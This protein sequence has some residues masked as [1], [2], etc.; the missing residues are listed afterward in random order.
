MPR[1][2]K[3]L[4]PRIAWQVIAGMLLI[5]VV[6]GFYW[7]ALLF[8]VFWQSLVSISIVNNIKVIWK[9]RKGLFVEGRLQR[10]LER[11]D[12]DGGTIYKALIVFPLP[13]GKGEKRILHQ[14]QYPPYDRYRIWVHPSEPEKSIATNYN[15]QLLLNNLFFLAI[16]IG[17]CFVDYFYL[18]E[19]FGK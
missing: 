6:L 18:V 19:I 7:L 11:S 5:H 8:C 16:V 2:Q 13:E 12:G 9:T 15:A 3:T 17:L 4:I 14:S 1:K 10:S